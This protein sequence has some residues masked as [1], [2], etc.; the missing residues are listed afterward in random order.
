VKATLIPA[1]YPKI[2]LKL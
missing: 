1:R 2:V